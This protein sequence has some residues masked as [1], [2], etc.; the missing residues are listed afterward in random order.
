VKNNK[1][2]GSLGWIA[3]LFFVFYLI[4]VA[5]RPQGVFWSV[6]EGGKFLYLQNILRTGDIKSDLVYLAREIDPQLNYVP[7]VYW[8][9]QDAQ[10]FSWWPVALSL[11]SLPFYQ[12]FGWIG[13]YILP[14][15]AGSLCILFVG[16]ITRHLCR[17]SQWAGIA[18]SSITGLATPILFYSTMFWEHTPSVALILAAFW[19]VLQ[20]MDRG[21]HRWM[22]LAGIL[23]SFS[24]YLRTELGTIVIA[25]GIGM[26][27]LRSWKSLFRFSAGLIPTTLGWFL[28]NWLIMG[29]PI[30]RQF[31][32]FVGM[33]SFIGIETAGLKFLGYLLFNAPAANG[34]NLSELWLG[35]GCVLTFIALLA[36]LLG[37][38]WW[39]TIP[40]Y[41]GVIGICSWG[42]FSPIEYKL[43][44]GA[45][46]VMP[47]LLFTSWGLIGKKLWRSSYFPLLFTLSAAI[48]GIVYLN[49]A[50]IQAGGVQWGPRYLLGMFPLAVVAS[51]S[52][53]FWVNVNWSR[54]SRGFLIAMVALSL[55]V[56]IGFEVRG[57][58][59]SRMMIQY[60]KQSAETLL[61][62]E[63]LPI[64]THWCFFA[65]IAP[66]V[67]WRQP[68]VN[69]KPGPIDEWKAYATSIN[70]KS[71][72]LVSVDLCNSSLDEVVR[73]RAIH[74]SGVDL[75]QIKL[76]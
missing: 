5:S 47:F 39:L 56:S 10:I 29:H 28:L 11:I 60:Y 32:T 18:A 20:N 44:S 61:Q 7:F 41:L 54:L 46:L 62:L 49:R 34:F 55:L 6:D 76:P 38:W 68:M 26:L 19:I 64:V 71:F 16:L 59:T 53:I 22:I 14:A 30:S 48:L 31:N 50:W 25:L 45:V 4:L 67:Y 3:I 40:A 17:E 51:V 24:V 58:K 73:N 8:A 1:R 35:I 52:G 75:E 66:D 23:A 12:L 36:P 21:E 69:I 43:V 33:D 15:A 27:W 63:P 72:Y 2:T 42:L 74:P 9:K 37:R 57:I 70:L 13:L 65:N